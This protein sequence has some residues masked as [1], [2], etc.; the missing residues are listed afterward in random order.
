MLLGL[1]GT[2]GGGPLELDWLDATA[3][4]PSIKA[5]FEVDLLN[6]LDFLV[7]LPAKL[8]RLLG[9][10]GLGN[11][12]GAADLMFGS[13]CLCSISGGGGGS[14]SSDNEMGSLSRAALG[15]GG[16]K[17]GDGTLRLGFLG[18]LSGTQP[19]GMPLHMF[20]L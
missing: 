15:G 9:E 11:S 8:L 16:G 1:R 19:S 20:T 2:N 5:S 4:P 3:L 14:G 10:C 17:S 13:A 12:S 7:V 6:M 18:G